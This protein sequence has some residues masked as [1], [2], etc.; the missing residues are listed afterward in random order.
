MP[1]PRKLPV[2]S[3]KIGPHLYTLRALQNTVE[4][5]GKWDGASLI[6]IN[7]S[8]DFTNIVDT[9]LHEIGHVISYLYRL[10]FMNGN[11][12]NRNTIY[13]T[14]FT[15]VWR[16]NPELFDWLNKGMKSGK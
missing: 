12:E 15:G 4:A 13:H 10:E 5:A 14:V 11:E 3:I 2:D 1:K 16:D 9:I 8:Q 7:M 6:E